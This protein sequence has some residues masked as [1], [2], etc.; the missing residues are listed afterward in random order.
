MPS[1]AR[2]S[3]ADARRGQPPGAAEAAGE[4]PEGAVVRLAEA[5]AR[6]ALGRGLAPRERAFAAGL[7]ARLGHALGGGLAAG[8]ETAAAGRLLLGLLEEE[9]EAEPAEASAAAKESALGRR[10][11]GVGELVGRR[12]RGFEE[13]A[14]AHRSVLAP[15][16]V[17]PPAGGAGEAA[18]ILVGELVPGADARGPP[19]L[20]CL[21]TGL[22]VPAAV[23][24]RC[25]ALVGD[26]VALV[27]WQFVLDPTQRI[28]AA[29]DGADV[30]FGFVEVTRAVPLVP[31]EPS[32]AGP[33]EAAADAD[34]PSYSGTVTAIGAFGGAT[35]GHNRIVELDGRTHLFLTHYPAD[36]VG[37]L[38]VGAE[39]R[40]RNFVFLEETRPGAEGTPVKVRAEKVAL[41]A[42]AA[43]RVEV[44]R[45]AASTVGGHFPGD[46]SEFQVFLSTRVA[47]L[48][49]L[50]AYQLARLLHEF[51]RCVGPGVLLRGG[52]RAGGGDDDD[53][54]GGGSGDDA[55]AKTYALVFPRP[56]AAVAHFWT[57]P[58]L[59]KAVARRE[60]A[61]LVPG[62]R[63]LGPEGP[64][65]TAW[66]VRWL[67]SGPGDWL[68]GRVVEAE[69]VRHPRARFVFR[70]DADDAARAGQP[71]VL[72]L[73]GSQ[74]W[75][76]R[77]VAGA[78]VLLS[79]FQVA[80]ASLGPAE[81]FHLVV[82]QEGVRVL[83]DAGG[84]RRP[85]TLRMPAWTPGP[86]EEVRQVLRHSRNRT[87]SF[88]GLIVEKRQ[89]GAD[90][91]ALHVAGDDLADVLRVYVRESEGFTLVPG[92][93]CTFHGFAARV[94][95][96]RHVYCVPG[97]GAH[98]A[99]NHVAADVGG[100]GAGPE[101][102][103]AAFAAA[104]PQSVR[105]TQER[106]TAENRA[107]GAAA[108][109]GGGRAGTVDQRTFF[110]VAQVAAIAA[111]GVRQA[112]GP[113]GPGRP[114]ATA[115]LRLR[116]EA[117][118]DDGTGQVEAC[119]AGRAAWDVLGLRPPEDATAVAA[120]GD[121][122]GAAS[123]SGGACPY[124]RAMGNV[125]AA[126]GAAYRDRT[127]RVR[128]T[129]AGRPKAP[130]LAF[131]PRRDSELLEDADYNRLLDLFERAAWASGQ[132]AFLCQRTYRSDGRAGPQLQVRE[133]RPVD[134]AC[135]VEHLR[136]RLRKR[137]AGG[138]APAK[139]AP[140]RGRVEEGR[141]VLGEITQRPRNA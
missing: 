110:L 113:D 34:A 89:A 91:H 126:F 134:T 70:Q 25:A 3:G 51:K 46:S 55:L 114:G 35:L 111:I 61:R 121:A 53:A 56:G 87:V 23:R 96:Q 26:V 107:A 57:L 136:R 131:G 60:E 6:R 115:H 141:R 64:V 38:R 118:L 30:G 68:L 109:A 5:A 103:W 52:A 42:T 37:G 12:V 63:D 105:G 49:P 97:P 4:G 75:M 86:E 140:G 130:A 17:A 92:M 138:E 48:A 7:P 125:A 69:D 13:V 36:V 50:A 94:S 117:V 77:F 80:R 74:P 88:S 102:F 59:R 128:N 83:E 19:S 76:L 62:H 101:K 54:S 10:L 31:R 18:P 116:V 129:N 137:K 135:Y 90:G 108:G 112:G 72:A 98:V 84:A 100:G 99:V 106:L 1:P 67:E 45:F 47:G 65:G 66:R 39:V 22:R 127:F 33:A 78:T 44:T 132:A 122:A 27:A 14:F 9:E 119:F 73:A 139:A 24:D 28:L 85:K 11:L 16:D 104:E 41:F 95:Q 79:R 32:G 43:S 124:V 82:R 8:A 133:V 21:R 15:G 29:A 20:R 2:V 120:A 93:H 123:G 40:V 58:E 81:E 71:F